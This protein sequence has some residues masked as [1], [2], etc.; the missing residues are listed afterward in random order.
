MGFYRSPRHIQLGGNL[1]IVTTLQE[2]VND[3]LFARTEPN[4]LFLHLVPPFCYCLPNRLSSFV[5][6]HSIH[7]AIVS[8][9]G[10]ELRG[11]PF[12]TVTCKDSRL[13]IPEL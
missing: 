5:D 2:Q 10:Q 3:L 9:E 7:I 13:H 11:K 12:S 4:S 6:L 1:G 8:P